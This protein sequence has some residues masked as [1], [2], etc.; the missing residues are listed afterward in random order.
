MKLIVVFPIMAFCL[1]FTHFLNGETILA[2]RSQALSITIHPEAGE[3]VRFAAED[4]ARIL[5]EMT[6]N[7]PEITE[8]TDPRGIIL[9]TTEQF[10]AFKDDPGLEI[11]HTFDGREAYIIRPDPEH[12][13][14]WILGNREDG[15]SHGVYSL[16]QKHG[17]RALFPGAN[18]EVIPKQEKVAVSSPSAGRPQVLTRQIWAGFG[19]FDKEQNQDVENWR[20]RNRL[21]ASIRGQIGHSWESMI[22]HE[23]EAFEANPQLYGEKADG[24][25]NKLSLRHGTQPVVDFTVEWFKRRLQD[26]RQGDILALAPTDGD[27]YSRDKET[28]A[29][30]EINESFYW[31]V[32]EVAKQMK[33]IAPDKLVGTTAYYLHAKPPPFDLESNV[34]V[35]GA[36]MFGSGGLSLEDFFTAW[37]KKTQYLGIRDYIFSGYQFHGDHPNGGYTKKAL[38]RQAEWLRNFKVSYY[39]AEGLW[40]WG[41]RGI[42]YYALA[43]LLW[44]PKQGVDAIYEDFQKSAYGA[45]ADAMRGYYEALEPAG[46]SVRQFQIARAVVALQEAAKATQSDPAASARIDDM[47]AFLVH[48]ALMDKMRALKKDDPERLALAAQDLEWNYRTR[49]NYILNYN[50]NRRMWMVNKQLLGNFFARDRSNF[51]L[52]GGEKPTTPEEQDAVI[53][54]ALGDKWRMDGGFIV[55]TAEAAATLEAPDSKEIREKFEQIV[56]PQYPLID[57]AETVY[58]TDYVPVDLGLQ[59]AANADAALW[60]GAS[61]RLL[62]WRPEAGRIQWT[63]TPNVRYRNRI[64]TRPMEIFVESPEGEMAEPLSFVQDSKP[65]EATV[66]IVQPGVS[67]L[68]FNTKRMGMLMEGKQWEYVALPTNEDTILFLN[69]PPR[70]SEKTFHPIYFYVPK[71]VTE[72]QAYCDLPLRI[73][74]NA[75]FSPFDGEAILP[76]IDGEIVKI[77]VPSGNDGKM[78]K[79]TDGGVGVRFYFLNLPNI[80]SFH[81]GKIL[82]SREVAEK[83]GLKIVADY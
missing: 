20:Q 44:D 46:K 69:A 23:K 43:Q 18:W 24:T 41:L 31:Y 39:S 80:F 9:G 58:S 82:I 34:I 25:L 67:E 19:T 36:T 4:L 37:S 70:D 56:V 17:Y 55:P 8:S 62:I 12:G 42:G 14:V 75:S 81:P 40:E 52:P 72:I 33:V 28:A 53:A 22:R 50:C 1:G 60:F 76:E 45:G 35:L 54:T 71:G 47:M 15:A 74:R 51:S 29:R 11:R 16:L 61:P 7:K 6:G 63:I 78:W 64:G 77:Q 68:F 83:D 27:N 73:I 57:V 26:P 2:D 30:G 66:E 10:G 13:R 32:N 21:G 5:G 49:R 59:P 79:I 3:R 65:K 38:E 48:S